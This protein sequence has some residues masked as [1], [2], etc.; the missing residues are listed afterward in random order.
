MKR[1]LY[2]LIIAALSIGT[3]KAQSLSDRYNE[4]HP[5]VMVCDWDKPPY[6]FLNDKG[7]PPAAT[8]ISCGPWLKT[9]HTHQ[10]RHEGMEHRHQDL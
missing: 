6:E 10:V 8:S 9:W 5:L 4:N 2:I 3:T 1:L 7:E